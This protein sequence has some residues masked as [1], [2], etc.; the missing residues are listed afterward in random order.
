M[1]PN[2]TILDEAAV[3]RALTRIAHEIL[4]R[5][6]GVDNCVLVGIRTRGIYLARR[7]ADRINRIEGVQVPVGELDITLYRDDLTEK[8]E[9]P[10]VRDSDLPVEIHGKTVV[11]VDDVLF[12][13]RT[14]RAAMDALIDRGRPHMIQLA[15]LVDRGHRELPIRPDYVGKNIP[16][17]KDE[18][19]RVEVSEHDQRDEVSI[20][21]K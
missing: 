16:T 7:L 10:E 2:K 15:V 21:R 3:R 17:S 11:L 14:V 19:V 6:K 20:G 1:A 12:T 4:E 18:I 8:T 5:N 13:G 9:Q